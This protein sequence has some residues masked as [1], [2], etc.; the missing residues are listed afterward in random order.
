MKNTFK[1]LIAGFALVSFVACDNSETTKTSTDSL[2]SASSETTTSGEPT[3]GSSTATENSSTVR[4]GTYIDLNTG[5]KVQIDRD[6]SSGRWIDVSTRTPI[7]YYI[8]EDTRDTFDMTGRNVNFAIERTLDGKYIINEKKYKVKFD[9]DGDMKVKDGEGNKM[10][11]DASSDE[12]KVK[13][14]TSKGKN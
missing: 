14:D 12:L 7:E 4:P 6:A 13:T 11:Y 1:V 3:S 8:S 5:K 2:N 9:S 10:K